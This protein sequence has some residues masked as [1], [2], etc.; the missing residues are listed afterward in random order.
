MFT[1][2]MITYKFSSTYMSVGCKLFP[3]SLA[4]NIQY[5]F[6]W[7]IISKVTLTGLFLLFVGIA[8]VRE[9]VLLEV[10]GRL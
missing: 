4:K 6:I 5:S 10:E 8:D 2:L 9:A 3:V 7:P 1:L